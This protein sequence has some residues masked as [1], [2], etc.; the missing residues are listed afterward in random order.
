MEIQTDLIN[1]RAWSFHRTT[2]IE[3][4]ELQAQAALAYLEASAVFDD[5]KGAKLTTFAYR[6]VTNNLIDFCRDYK[7]TDI[8]ID[9]NDNLFGGSFMKV[10]LTIEETLKK[11]PK[12]VSDLIEII[13]KHSDEEQFDF[14]NVRKIIGHVHYVLEFYHN[15]GQRRRKRAVRQLKELLKETPEGELF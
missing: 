8:K 1:E 5:N 11:F 10:G 15:W 12:N 14:T 3:F 4:E 2:G 13:L 6:A 9:Y 7:Q